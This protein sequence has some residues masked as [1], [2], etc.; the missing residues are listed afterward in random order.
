MKN[1]WIKI[2]PQVHPDFDTP[3]IGRLKRGSTY[4]ARVVELQSI[5]TTKSF[6]G[7]KVIFN[8]ISQDGD[9]LYDDVTHYQPLPSTDVE[10]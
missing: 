9:E 5:E 3:V 4:D 1:N 8:Y 10:D 6:S 2:T 7:E